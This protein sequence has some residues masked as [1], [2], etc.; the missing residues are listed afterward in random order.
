LLNAEF[1]VRG[2]E[3]SIVGWFVTGGHDFKQVT[4]GIDSES[5]RPARQ[6]HLTCD[7]MNMLTREENNLI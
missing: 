5:T 7:F 2:F 1:V 6:V 4:G 3:L